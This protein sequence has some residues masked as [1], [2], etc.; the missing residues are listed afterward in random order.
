MMLPSWRR[1]REGCII[2]SECKL[3]FGCESACWIAA[4]PDGVSS[5][6]K[7]HQTA[8]PVDAGISQ[9]PHLQIGAV[10]MLRRSLAGLSDR[11]RFDN[12]KL[13]L[14][15]LITGRFYGYPPVGPI[16]RISF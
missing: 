9:I 2:I 12:Q 8:N 1:T 14:M 3:F 10:L 13:K 11:C 15:C 6:H 4:V 16:K 5:G 7:Q